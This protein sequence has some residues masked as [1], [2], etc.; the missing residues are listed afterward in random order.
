MRR[1]LQSK[2]NGFAKSQEKAKQGK[3]TTS[4]KERAKSGPRSLGRHWL[5]RAR[6][7]PPPHPVERNSLFTCFTA[8]IL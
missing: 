7:P 1:F 8:A 3:T 5:P 4:I 6:R 2:Q